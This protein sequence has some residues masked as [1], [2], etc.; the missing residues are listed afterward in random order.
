MPWNIRVR[1]RSRRPRS[2]IPGDGSPDAGSSI[3]EFCLVAILLVTLLLGILQ[4][5]FYLYIRNVVTASAA[6]GAR[7]AANADVPVEAGAERA[8][9]ILEQ[10][11]GSGTASRLTCTGG[12]D[13]GPGGV[14]LSFVRCTGAIPVFFVPAGDVLSIDVT[15]H[16]VEEGAATPGPA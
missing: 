7:Y 8:K 10:G 5:A 13:E 1:D 2:W 12:T 15:G 3:V 4:V 6:E 9:S 16:A 11:V 14:V